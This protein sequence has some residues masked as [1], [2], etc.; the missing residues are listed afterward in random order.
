MK[1]ISWNI[2]GIRAIEKK[3]F[4]DWLQ[5][6]SPDI[7]GVQEIKAHEEQLSEKLLTPKGYH[8][9]FNPAERKGYSGTAI[10]TKI[11]PKKIIKGIGIKEFDNEGRTIAA[12]FGDFVFI[13]VYFPNGNSK[14]ERLRFKLNFYRESLNYYNSLLAQGKKLVIVG[15]YNTAHNEID[16]AR[17]KENESVSGF[18]RIE[19]DWLDE[20]VKNGYIDTFRHF[21]KDPDHYTWWSFRTRARDRNVGWRIDYAFV[22]ENMKK[23]L[24]N[25]YHLSGVMGSDHCPIV[26]ELN[27]D[28]EK[29]TKGI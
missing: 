16:L 2:N 19:R 10:F 29:L 26:L 8:V 6:E 14:E 4:L 22:S 24:K 23:E 9:F 27:L 1:I 13:N 12:D 17:P 28:K 7:L 11:K 3:G 20:L 5:K 25:S 15:D 18:L 21:N